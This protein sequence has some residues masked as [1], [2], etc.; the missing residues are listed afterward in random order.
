[1]A[2]FIY[3]IMHFFLNPLANLSIPNSNKVIL[4]RIETI[5]L[6]DANS[7]LQAKLDTG[8]DSSALSANAVY[9]F[10]QNQ[11]KWLTFSL[12]NPQTHKTVWLKK[13]IVKWV[14]IKNRSDECL[15]SKNNLA[16][17]LSARPVIQCT[18]VVGRKKLD[19]MMSLINRSHFKYPVLLGRD[20]II[21]L[22]GLIDVSREH[23]VF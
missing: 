14:S 19:V 2:L 15:P 5:K 4:G 16:E 3:F 7:Y 9:Y 17:K 11:Q 1:M 23:V 12:I 8:A 21:K 13:K 20:A 6:I 22:N 10:N 18:I